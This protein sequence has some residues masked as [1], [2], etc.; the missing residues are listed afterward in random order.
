MKVVIGGALAAL[1]LALVALSVVQRVTEARDDPPA[2]PM[3]ADAYYALDAPL[4]CDRALREVPALPL[5]AEPVAL[6]ICADPDGSLPWTSPTDLVEGDLAPLVEVLADLEPTPDES[7]DCTF[8]GGPGYDLMLRF[9][10]DRYARIHGD[11]G[12]CGVVSVASRDY[13]GADEVL[14][15]ALALVDRQRDA[16]PVPTAVPEAP[17]CPVDSGLGSAYSLTGEVTDVVV[18]VSCWRTDRG[19]QLPPWSD[20]VRVRPKD[21]RVLVRDMTRNHGEPASTFAQLGC[22][23]GRKS[24]YFQV[25]VGRTAWGDVVATN[26]ECQQFYLPSP[27]LRPVDRLAVWQPGKRAQG[28]LDSLRR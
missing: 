11:T 3:S 24:F 20:P 21:L 6:L 8:Q 7:Y 2:K 26:G 15:A 13:F 10:R 16:R 19:K 22:P 28:I 1:V 12:G 17:G 5:E 14:D 25:L 18:A 27:R 23:D 9:S 4:T